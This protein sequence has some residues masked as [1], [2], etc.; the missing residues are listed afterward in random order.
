M[1]KDDAIWGGGGYDIQ[2]RSFKTGI[3]QTKRSKE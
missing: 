3:E 2:K 1:G